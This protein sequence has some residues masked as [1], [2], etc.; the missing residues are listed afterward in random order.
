MRYALRVTATGA[1]PSQ[2][3]RREPVTVT[4]E[5]QGGPSQSRRPEP[6]T[7]TTEASRRTSHG[8]PR[9]PEL[10]SQ[11]IPDRAGVYN[12]RRAVRDNMDPPTTRASE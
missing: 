6:V 2:P 4:R 10:F 7:A 9:V 12:T 8:D 5:G 1:T 3:R 11:L